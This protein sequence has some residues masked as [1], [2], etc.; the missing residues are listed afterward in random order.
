VHALLMALQIS[1][2]PGL[3]GILV[4]LVG[5]SVL[6]GSVFLLLSTNV[7]ARVGVLITV[8]GL[9]GWLMLMGMVWAIYGIGYKGP[10]PHWKVEEVVTSTSPTDLSSS[11]LALAH[12]LSSWKPQEAD[13]PHRGEEQAAAFATLIDKAGPVPG[14]YASEADFITVTAF[15]RG[16]KKKSFLNNWVPGPHPPHYAI[17]QVRGTKKQEIPFGSTPPAAQADPSTPVRSVVLV[18]DLG[19]LRLPSVSLALSMSIVFA[20]ACNALHRRDKQLTAARAALA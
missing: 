19:A 12:D 10:A 1:W 7:G 2:D 13:D 16:G 5:A 8:A 20:L 3:R 6:M 4:V 17:I 18:R 15:E 11:K 9:S 14:V